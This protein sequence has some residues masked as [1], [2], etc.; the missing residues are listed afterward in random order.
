MQSPSR[1]LPVSFHKES[2]RYLRIYES[3]LCWREEILKILNT[4]KNISGEE[5]LKSTESTSNEEFSNACS[6]NMIKIGLEV[7]LLMCVEN[8][9]V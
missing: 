4:K 8:V 1:H 3:G 9:L 7:I 2:G 5:L 6:E